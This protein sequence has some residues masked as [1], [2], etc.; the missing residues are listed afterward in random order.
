MNVNDF[1]KSINEKKVGSRYLFV[2]SDDY[3]ISILTKGLIKV[4]GIENPD[5]NITRF[6]EAEW[7]FDKI[8]E[9]I[10]TL[11]VFSNKK[12]TIINITEAKKKELVNIDSFMA[13]LDSIPSDSVLVMILGEN[14]IDGIDKSKFTVVDTA[15]VDDKFLLNRINLV[16]AKSAGKAIDVN[17]ANLL[18]EYS[19]RDLGKIT[20]EAKKLIHYVGDSPMI[21]VKDVMDN[22]EKTLDY[23]IYELTNAL[24]KKD[25]VKTYTI[26]NSMKEK[27]GEFLG[28][29]GLIYNY[30]RR[31]LHVSLSKNKDVKQLACDLGVKE[32]AVK[33][34]ITQEKMFGAMK[35]K[36]ICDICMKYDYETKRTMTTIE[37]A[38]DM[39]VLSILNM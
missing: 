3:L 22:V 25:S 7:D 37:N 30:F 28:V 35:L 27:K 39:I 6:V 36:N 15:S 14:T 18:I 20:T 10:Q 1:I 17:A 16:V 12:I 26:I 11:P 32:G 19:N 9:S 31:L 23:E 21:T 38:V 33:F 24:A 34:A 13:R 4:L 5:F 2:G 8:Y 29:V